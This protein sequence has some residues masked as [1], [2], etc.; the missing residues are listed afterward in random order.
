M[1]FAVKAKEYSVSLEVETLK[2]AKL[3]FKLA[4]NF[5]KIAL[6]GSPEISA[7]FNTSKKITRYLANICYL[8]T[9]KVNPD[10]YPMFKNENSEKKQKL[11]SLFD[12]KG[13]RNI[14]RDALI[15]LTPL[16]LV[17][18]TVYWTV[19]GIN[20]LQDEGVG[21][22][23]EA[24]AALYAVITTFNAFKQAR[25]IAAVYHGALLYKKEL[26]LEKAFEANPALKTAVLNLLAASQ[27]GKKDEL[28]GLQKEIN[29]ILTK[30]LEA[31]NDDV[32]ALF[33]KYVNGQVKTGIR[34]FTAKKAIFKG[35]GFA[36]R[37]GS[38]AGLPVGGVNK[39]LA[40]ITGWMA[41]HKR[42]RLSPP[43]KAE[44]KTLKKN[45]KKEKAKG[46]KV[47]KEGKEEKND[48]GEKNVFNIEP[49]SW[50]ASV[51][52]RTP[53]KFKLRIV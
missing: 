47:E 22:T 13:F 17:T 37:F 25:K 33:K 20:Y 16:V 6:S 18:Y 50:M 31:G 3:G 35:L 10:A 43:V 12:N 29:K 5:C 48:K 1:S 53:F 39:V 52:M 24:E 14:T 2:R 8:E 28:K 45:M 51:L 32:K 40:V 38:M 49:L 36:L 9:G 11:Y 34:K 21:L 7:V 46:E 41:A 42:G 15:V 23:H 27:N 44:V 19:L 26:E 4:T 30:D